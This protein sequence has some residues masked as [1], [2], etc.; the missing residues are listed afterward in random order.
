[1]FAILAGEQ[2]EPAGTIGYWEREHE[3]EAAWETGW[4]VLPA[5]QGHG[6]ATTATLAIIAMLRA[7][8]SRRW[9]FAYPTIDN[10]ASNAVCR[11]AGF[12]LL[13]TQQYEYP[14]GTWIQCNTWR[15]ALAQD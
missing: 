13:G 1:M 6:L 5:W 9:L 14:K 7:E 2:Q 10:A 11:K 4:A 8:G 3:G 12:A 15:A